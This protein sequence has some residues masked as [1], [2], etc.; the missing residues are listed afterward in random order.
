M[1]QKN[2][3]AL[4]EKTAIHAK[5]GSWE[6]DFEKN[7]IYW[8]KVT[9][10]I[11]DVDENFQ[12]NF[13]NIWSFYKDPT[14][15][16][17]IKESYKKAIQQDIEYDI[18]VKINTAKGRDIWVRAIGVPVFKN[19]KCIS[20]YGLFQ[21]IDKE[22]RKQERLHRQLQITNDVLKNTSIG[23]AFLDKNGV[24][25]NT[26]DGLCKIMGYSCDVMEE[27]NFK[28]YIIQKNL[29]RFLIS[30]NKLKEGRINTYT[31]EKCL[32]H[33][34]GNTL[35]IHLVLTVIRDLNGQI[36]N[37]LAQIIDLSAQY[38]SKQK[39]TSYLDIT[40]D[41]NQR[42]INFAHIVSHNLKSHSGN[43]S[44]LLELMNSDYPELQENELMP[45]LEQSVDNLSET[46]SHLN[47]V[48]AMQ[49]VDKKN[50]E[51]L[52]LLHYVE[53]TVENVSASIKSENAHL[54]IDVDEKL[55][56]KAIPAYLESILLNLITNA[57]KY[58]NPE[59]E[60]K[61]KIAAKKTANFIELE[62]IDNG[63]GMDLEKIGAKLFGMYKTFHNHKDSRGI[64]LFITKN[65]I[66][67][68]GGS[69][70]VESEINKGSNFKVYLK[71]GKE[72]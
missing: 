9:K 25:K 71:S 11:H 39:L 72:I 33:K 38:E 59:K 30:F 40:T 18:K 56:V 54:Q 13:E 19:G 32:K 1:S 21:D 55:K 15:F 45:L 51:N 61:I 23:I 49:N 52:N 37:F 3:N 70:E 57:I 67:A 26:N 60:L 14:S 48:V 22:E 27:T 24:I 6:I 63:L 36:L 62:V 53:K 66:E 5:M 10:L 41:Q 65:Q 31:T 20:I 64:G 34:N 17:K 16:K 35:H 7:E 69:I 50:I 8:S 4:L 46:I 68:L 58:R 2:F 44:M 12:C 28:E 47:E 42:L 43:L 29:E